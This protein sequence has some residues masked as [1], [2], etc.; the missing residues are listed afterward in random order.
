[1]NVWEAELGTIPLV[2]VTGVPTAVAVPLQLGLAKTSY[3]TV[4]PALYELLIVAESDTRLPTET[5][6]DERA[7]AIVG[8][9]DC[10]VRGS[11]EETAGLLFASPL[12]AAWKAKLPVE[13]NRTALEL[14]TKPPAMVTIETEFPEAA[15]NAFVNRE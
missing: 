5:V 1:L 3:V 4:P 12:Y 14:G 9:A 7:V 2:T 11:H 6:V 15:Q 13:L 8:L 10:T